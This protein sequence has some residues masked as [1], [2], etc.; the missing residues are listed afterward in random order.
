MLKYEDVKKKSRVLRAMTSLDVT[1]FDTL[2][3]EL[4]R[5]WAIYQKTQAVPAPVRQRRIGG[6][7]KSA[8]PTVE[9]KLLFI[10]YYYKTYPLQEVL[11]FLFGMEQGTACAWIHKLSAVL[12]W[13]LAALQHLP[14]REPTALDTTLTACDAE[15]VALDGTERRY[16][17]P[18]DYETQKAYYSGKKHAH[19][20]K[21]NIVA[22]VADR[23]VRYLSKTYQ[24]K[25]QDKK[26]CDLEA[27]TFPPDTIL[28]QDKGFQGYAPEGVTIRQP[29]KKPRG[30]KLPAEEKV[31]NALISSVR[32]VVEHVIAGI[33]RCRI[34]KDVFRNTT[35]GFDDL[36]MEIACGLHNFRTAA[37]AQP[38]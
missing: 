7:R 36:V 17:R 22:T 35:A 32:I 4:G 12:K 33:K 29:M 13:A 10:L 3:T 16:H 19:T 11:A 2:A 30:K 27:P 25:T 1:E 38:S 21:N 28:Y 6:G 34:V 20:L 15:V 9:D 18:S 26:I 31:R 14:T 8:L 23:Q 37:R 24:G 5:Q